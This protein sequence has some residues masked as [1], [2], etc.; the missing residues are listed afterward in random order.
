[1]N[2][3]I[4][5]LAPAGDF[6]KAKTAIDFGADAVYIGGTGYSLRARAN[7]FSLEDISKI[8]TYVHSKHKK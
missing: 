6:N 2:K 5:L 3:K 7:N 8:S 1:M 4:E